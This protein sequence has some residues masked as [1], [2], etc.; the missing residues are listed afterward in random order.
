MQ[1]GVGWRRH[2]DVVKDTSGECATDIDSVVGIRDGTVG[3]QGGTGFA[4]VI[5]QFTWIVS[6]ACDKLVTVLVVVVA[7]VKNVNPE[8]HLGDV[9]SGNV[10]DRHGQTS[11]LSTLHV[12][13]VGIVQADTVVVVVS[14]RSVAEWVA[15]VTRLSRSVRWLSVGSFWRT[16]D[17]VEVERWGIVTPVSVRVGT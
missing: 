5:T 15:D 13:R 12:V 10:H 11:T 3:E 14:T 1:T 4:E 6:G 17:T 8:R 7:S 9:G 2:R 16:V